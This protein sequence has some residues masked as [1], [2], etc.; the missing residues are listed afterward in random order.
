M[1]NKLY[2]M[3]AVLVLAS[4]VITA[5]GA[6]TEAPA[7]A[8]EAPAVD[9]IFAAAKQDNPRTPRSRWRG[10]QRWTVGKSGLKMV[11]TF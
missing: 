4:M 5:C 7:A 6:A 8:T 1:S 3:L 9:L 10:G 2:T 11:K